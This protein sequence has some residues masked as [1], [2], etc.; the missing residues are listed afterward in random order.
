VTATRTADIVAEIRFRITDQATEGQMLDAVLDAARKLDIM[1]ET[2]HPDAIIE[3]RV[4]SGTVV[5]VG[6]GG[7]L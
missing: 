7:S 2:R 6:T 1:T 5:T 3:I 4:L